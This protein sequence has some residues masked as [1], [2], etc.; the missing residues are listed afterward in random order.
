MSD[1]LPNP[2]GCYQH[3]ACVCYR[4]QISRL[5]SEIGRLKDESRLLRFLNK[6]SA[7]SVASA[8]KKKAKRA[9]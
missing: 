8:E 1:Y 5:K 3:M 4:A 9:R 6:T 2:G 7:R